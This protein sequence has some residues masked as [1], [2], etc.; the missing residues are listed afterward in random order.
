V[1]VQVRF[2]V[3]DWKGT[4]LRCALNLPKGVMVW[5]LSME[6][7]NRSREWGVVELSPELQAHGEIREIRG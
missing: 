5:E 2:R 3:C 1:S 6:M 7:S 4:A